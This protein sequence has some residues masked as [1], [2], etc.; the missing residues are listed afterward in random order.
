MSP[1]ADQEPDNEMMTA[2]NALQH[3]A[4]MLSIMAP[5]EKHK[6]LSGL[7]S[8]QANGRNGN[9]DG[10]G[11]FVQQS[12]RGV[13]PNNKGA[14]DRSR[15]PARDNRRPAQDASLRKLYDRTF[16]DRFPE[17]SPIRFTGNGR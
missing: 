6:F 2:A 9:G 15:R 1:M 3:V 4:S 5:E 16:L 14:L 7:G 13:A 12:T 8:L 17:A 11:N 10:N